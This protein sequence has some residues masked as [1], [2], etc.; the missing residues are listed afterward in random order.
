MVILFGAGATR[1]AFDSR[2]PPPPLDAD[3]FE[4][5]SQLSGR[6]TRRLARKVTKNVFDLYGRVTDVGLEQYYRD[7]ET[8]LELSRFA[9]SRNR[10]MDWRDRTSDLEEL[11][12]RVLI[13]T[14]CDLDQGPARACRSAIHE[15]ILRH[16]RK[17]D[18]VVT[19]NYDTV[20]EA[21]MP[22]DTGWTPRDGYGISATGITLDWSNQWF[23]GREVTKMDSAEFKLLKLHGSINWTLY[24]NSNVR[25]KPRPYLVRSRAGSAIAEEVA[26]LPPGWHKRVDKNPYNSLWREARLKLEACASLV[27]IGYSLP[28]TDL[29]ARALFLE[30]NRLRR[31]RNKLL[32]ELH[33][34]DVS[35]SARKRLI[36]VFVP[37][38]GPTGRVFRYAGIAEFARKWA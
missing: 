38:L 18:T 23:S 32:K 33:V 14:T 21:A 11:V 34:A 8:R 15:T 30:V 29:I 13:H 16:V 4:I 37:A 12:R 36:D 26:I 3:F 1:G 27:I 6:G 2:T 5:A 35:D 19:F 31:A 25:L 20:I 7:I 28:E 17:G 9:R 22:H 10:P 24:N